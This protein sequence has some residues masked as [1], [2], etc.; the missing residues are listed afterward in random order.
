MTC[1]AARFSQQLTT[2]GPVTPHAPVDGAIREGEPPHRSAH[3]SSLATPL[4]GASSLCPGALKGIG[5]GCF[6]LCTIFLFVAWERYQDYARK[7][8]EANRVLELFVGVLKQT[9]GSA[10]LVEGTSDAGVPP[11]TII[12][13]LFAALS[14]IG[15]AV[16]FVV[17]AKKGIG[18]NKGDAARF[19][20]VDTVDSQNRTK[21]CR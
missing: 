21:R 11:A 6:V 5:I 16:C 8:Q 1:L 20:A 12:S 4:K 17:A 2:G 3:G 10:P 18:T 13:L 14:A 7:V 15:G 19:G 9:T